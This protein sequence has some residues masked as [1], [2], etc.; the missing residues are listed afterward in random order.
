[1]AKLSFATLASFVLNLNMN[2][3]HTPIASTSQTSPI[4]T[5]ALISTGLDIGTGGL[6]PRLYYRTRIGG[7]TFGIALIQ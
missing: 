2:I 4:I 6:S 7:G 1:M 5:S 3:I